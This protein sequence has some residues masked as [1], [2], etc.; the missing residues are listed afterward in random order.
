MK[1]TF[2]SKFEGKVFESPADGIRLLAS[3]IQKAP[4]KATTV[5]TEDVRLYLTQIA[6]QLAAKHGAAWPGG[7][8]SNSLSRRSGELVSSI[9][10]GVRV[11]KTF[12]AGGM[13]GYIYGNEYTRAHENG[14]TLSAHGARY[15][16]IP[17]PTALNA[18]GTPIHSNPR[19]WP[20][21]FVGVSRLGNLLIFMRQGAEIIPLY[22]LK[23]SVVLRPR[24]GIAELSKSNLPYF[25]D[26]VA[27]T[28]AAAFTDKIA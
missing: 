28:V 12:S 3:K 22:V 21:T 20:N 19:D 5:L 1:I 14:V 11:D 10:N 27:N 4:A 7:T 8:S 23:T 24:L 6:M 13:V 25:M 2:Q 16:A 26:R 9:L 15:L 18:N 17:L